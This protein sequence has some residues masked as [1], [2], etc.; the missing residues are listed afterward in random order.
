[1]DLAKYYDFYGYG[2]ANVRNRIKDGQ[3]ELANLC[4]N[5]FGNFLE[6]NPR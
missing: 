5:N 4:L 3:T 2:A 6:A 1:M